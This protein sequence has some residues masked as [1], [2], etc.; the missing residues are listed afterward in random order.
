MRRSASLTAIS[1]HKFARD[2]EDPSG[3]GTVYHRWSIVSSIG[4]AVDTDTFKAQAIS[5]GEPVTF[6]DRDAENFLREVKHGPSSDRQAQMRAA[7]N[8][9]A[10]VE[11]TRSVS[12]LLH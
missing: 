5:L 6:R 12:A 1:V 11:T 7:V 3:D 8:A 2:G 10:A 9:A 4:M